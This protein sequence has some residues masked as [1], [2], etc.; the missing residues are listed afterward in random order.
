M[1][2][3]SLCGCL[4]VAGTVRNDLFVKVVTAELD[5][6]LKKTP[7]NLEV[8]LVVA[9]SMGVELQVVSDWKPVMFGNL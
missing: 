1:A 2:L 6:D 8:R 9:D 7:K 4:C 5:K 3:T